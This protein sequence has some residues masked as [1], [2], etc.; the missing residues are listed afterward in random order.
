METQDNFEVKDGVLIKY[1]GNSER[2][3]VPD[4]VKMIAYCAFENCET[5]KEIIIHKS[6]FHVERAAFSDCVNLESIVVDPDNPVYHSKG[7]CLIETEADVLVAGCKTS[8]I[9]KE[10]GAIGPYAFF[11][12][13]GLASI[14]IPRSISF[15]REYAFCQCASL[16][17]IHIPYDVRKIES[18]AFQGNNLQSI[19]VDEDNINYHG[20]GNCLIETA[21]KSLIAG[22]QN[23]CVPNDRSVT[24]IDFAAFSGC[25]NLRE[26]IIP[27]TITA[28]EGYAFS[29]CPDLLSLTIPSA[30]K[31][32]D[33]SAFN[34][35]PN[36]TIITSEGSRA[37]YLANALKI[38]RQ[39][40]A[41]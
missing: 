40:L 21:Y 16:A 33:M 11:N 18:F 5:M 24:S 17:S 27:D 2:V 34:S 6:V 19:T 22:C 32:I 3:V 7:S 20:V 13:T 26:L 35:S 36:L 23:S 9:P 25:L 29:D 12:C 15:I 8:V 38:P 10:V 30:V 39:L 4:K 14:E 31:S 37:D 41:T 1:R 28:I